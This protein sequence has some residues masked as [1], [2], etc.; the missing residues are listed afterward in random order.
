MDISKQVF[1]GGLGSFWTGALCASLAWTT[2][3]PL[4]VAKSQLQ[5]GNYEGKS[6]MYLLKDLFRTG[7][8]FRGIVPGLTRSAIAN[9]CSMVVYKKV[10]SYFLERKQH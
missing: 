6:F 7:L 5:S 4:D 8:I 3:W 2:V 9:G 1:D 10:E